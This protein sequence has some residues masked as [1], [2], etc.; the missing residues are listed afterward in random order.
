MYPSIL[1][2]LA[3]PS[4]AFLGLRNGLRRLGLAHLTIVAESQSG[5]GED[6]VKL[7]SAVHKYIWC[8][9]VSN[10]GHDGDDERHDII[11]AFVK[12]LSCGK[13]LE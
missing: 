8:L 5:K 9:H 4:S 6:F 13:C 1:K 12:A 2:L 11:P 10:W 3:K 7:N